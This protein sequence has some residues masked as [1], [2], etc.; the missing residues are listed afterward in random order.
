MDYLNVSS[1]LNSVRSQARWRGQRVWLGLLLI[2]ARGL[3]VAAAEAEHSG[4]P[5][6]TNL[7]QV[8]ALTAAQ[9][10]AQW[11]V[12]VRAV[13]TYA[14]PA[15]WM[16]F[17]QDETE[18]VY[19]GYSNKTVSVS[20]GDWV[21]VEGV[22][23]P[24]VVNPCIGDGKLT[25]LGRRQR[26]V[27]RVVSG[28]E[29]ATNAPDSRWVQVSG[30]VRQIRSFADRLEFDLMAD[31]LH[32]PVTVTDS[33]R[34]GTE[35]AFAVNA[36]VQVRGVCGVV[37]AP[38]RKSEGAHLYVPTL[39]T[40]V[41]VLRSAPWWN[42][43][44]VLQLSGVMGFAVLVA[45][46]WGVVLRRRMEGQQRLLRE[47]A[48]RQEVFSKLSHRLS[49]AS[50]PQEAARI[51][52][53]VA[54]D[55]LGWDAFC[56][57]L[58]VPELNRMLPI[59]QVDV[60]GGS[61]QDEVALPE[62]AE[63]TA[64]FQRVLERGGFL[65]ETGQPGQPELG[66][67]PFGDK[68]RESACVLYVP[69]RIG[70]KVTGMLSIHSYTPRAYDGDDLQ[71]LQALADHCAG[72]LERIRAEGEIRKLA[73]F[74]QFNPNP[75]LEF[76][77]DGRIAYCND[78]AVKMARALKRQHPSEILPSDTGEIIKAC[79]AT[80]QS[81]LRVET[82]VEERTISWSFFPVPA[83]QVVHCYAGDITERLNLEAQLRQAQK[84]ESIGR[85]AG[86]VAHDFNNILTVIQGHA[87]LL[88][89][90]SISRQRVSES[91]R[92]VS[93]A[94]ERAANLTRQLLTFSRKQ[95][96]QF[97]RVDLNEVVSNL[98]GM[99]GRLIG[100]DVALHVHFAA[101]PPMVHADVS[102]ME[103]VFLNLAVNARDAMPGGGDLTVHLETLVVGEADLDRHPEGRLGDFACLEVK[104]TGCGMSADVQAHIFEPFFTT[105]DVGKGTGLGLATVY[106]IVQ[107]HSGWIEVV[108]VAQQGTTFRIYLP[109][110]ERSD[111][112]AKVVENI[113]APRGGAETI[114]V[115][116]DEPA[117]RELVCRVLHS[118]GYKVLVADSGVSALR[119]WEKERDHID[120]LLTDVVMPDGISG[121]DLVGRLQQER[122]GLK[123]ILSSG[124]SMDLGQSDMEI[125][126][127]TTVLSKPY[128]IN[129]LVNVVRES[130][131]GRSATVG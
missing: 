19:V 112:P 61:R 98:S 64:R 22:S 4:V 99:I 48:R 37:V 41:T 50:T 90:D 87:G 114:L 56:A 32:V 116:E 97:V 18:G 52:A 42:F 7:S 85:L 44:R 38:G 60:I 39:A 40:D 5:V 6:L 10:A 115:V 89:S 130:L 120:L 43:Q 51:I 2:L 34:K 24:G 26:L 77:S 103:Q 109:L 13:V 15:G 118:Y 8:R 47:Q 102:M 82:Q 30:V 12:R 66:S 84:M 75:V 68:A 100:E 53:G 113:P 31:D 107:E 92:E 9:A 11:P 1:F 83:S 67:L 3:A 117:V 20:P 127:G 93:R 54:D 23:H 49:S 33:S 80:G 16:L 74:P 104:D 70:A 108:S 81:R 36:L 14:G 27:P 29:L 126:P 72:A 110:L 17:M 63:V 122:P 125:G 55:L 65:Y 124:Y 128:Q 62:Y 59:L 86:G 96:M 58:Y 78:A 105:K 35:P 119:I 57:N 71:L 101:H 69:I 129:T 88:M 46:G 121:L 106:G 94:A 111:A 45:L 28:A 91:A 76:A 25:V 73:S 21:E 123:V 95:P 131:D 79:L